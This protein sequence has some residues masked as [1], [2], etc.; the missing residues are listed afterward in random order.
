MT[1]VLVVDDDPQIVELLRHWLELKRCE[2]LSARNGEKAIQVAEAESPDLILLDVIMPGIS[3]IDTCQRLRTS[4]STAQ[5]PVILVTAKGPTEARAEGM[6]AGAVDYVTK[7]IDFNDLEGRIKAAL[8]GGDDPQARVERLL[9]ETVHAALSILSC[10]LAWLLTVDDGRA[11]LVGRALATAS[12]D[13][14]AQQFLQAVSGGQDRFQVPLQGDG[15]PLAEVALNRAGQFNLSLADLKS[16]GSEW[17]GEGC[18]AL[19]AGFISILPLQLS[20]PASGVLV[21]GTS[22]PRDMTLERERQLVASVASQ[23]AV[24]VDNVRLLQDLARSERLMRQERAFRQMLLDTMSDGLLALTGDGRIQFVNQRLCHMIGYDASQL[25]S[26]PVDELFHPHDRKSVRRFFSHQPPGGTAALEHHLLRRDGSV[27]PV[28]ASQALVSADQ[29]GRGERV[30]VLTDLSEQR[31]REAAITRQSQRLTALN[32]ATRVLA[33][34]LSLDEVIRLILEEATSALAA[35]SASVLLRAGENELVFRDAV[36]PGAEEVRGM[37]MTIDQGVAGW[38]ARHAKP[39]LVAE[40]ASD[41]RFYPGVDKATGLTTSSLAAVPLIIEGEVI[42]VVEVVN[43]HEGQFNAG[44]LE[45][46]EGLA[47]SAAAALQNARLFEE[48]N[49][50]VEELTLLL[51]VSGAASSTLAIG[52]VLRRVAGR[53]IRSLNAEWCVV[54]AWDRAGDR[55][56]WLAEVA[57]AVWSVGKGTCYRLADCPFSREALETGTPFALNINDVGADPAAVA[58]MHSLGMRS[59]LSMPV[60]IDGHVVGLAELYKVDEGHHFLPDDLS[61]CWEAMRAWRGTLSDQRPWT[62]S[63][64]LRTLGNALQEAAAAAWCTVFAYHPGQEQI[65]IVHELGNAV[66]PDGQ[67]VI[68]TVGRE[69]LNSAALITGQAMAASIG[70]SELPVEEQFFVRRPRAGALLAAPLMVRGEAIGLVQLI[71]TNPTRRFSDTEIS[72]AQG[73]ANVVGSALENAQLYTH[74]EKRAEQL[75]AAY[76]DLQEADRLKDEL[77]QNVSH[78]LRTPLTFLVGYADLILNGD[79]GPLTDEQREALEVVAAKSNHLTRLVED[80]IIV[81]RSETR[82]LNR[83]RT[84]LTQIAEAAIRGAELSAA[85]NGVQLV[86]DF[87]PNLPDVMVDSGRMGEVFDNLLSNAIKFSP[88]GGQVTITMQDLGA[89]LRVEMRDQ[90]IGIPADQHDK[91]WRRFYQVDGSATRHFGGTG[92]GLAIVKSIVEAHGGNVWVESVSGQGST[93]FF[94]VPK[95][96]TRPVATPDEHEPKR[97]PLPT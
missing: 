94:T 19:G 61:H 47:R 97:G 18:A 90:G 39:A 96:E 56:V 26:R 87:A 57:D 70:T 50:R 79:F 33:S 82:P 28:L 42:G 49:R 11:A 53:L 16:R 2:V 20:G 75:E 59:L 72:L 29:G 67:G 9:S 15:G 64:H 93:F 62:A 68:Q 6:L 91:I 40:A 22:T 7:P 92:L 63:Q 95:S 65:E 36:G 54:S 46:L 74:L 51:R 45:L 13:Q 5:I 30:I 83:V 78:E 3:G 27:V 17:L 35:A 10:E 80:I 12:G 73:I 60:V 34:T 21:L 14:A 58:N 48:V 55:L 41:E 44:D 66:W 81:Q 77:I 69:S 8:V 31:A 1:K 71:D 84:S 85:E 52:D 43:K 37:R 38:V 86:C 25:R 4:P 32:R 89:A 76:R 23:A 24:V 88:N